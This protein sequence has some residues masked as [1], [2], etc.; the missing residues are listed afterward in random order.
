MYHVIELVFCLEHGKVIFS[1][2]IS[3]YPAAPGQRYDGFLWAFAP[4]SARIQM[5]PV[6]MNVLRTESSGLRSGSCVLWSKLVASFLLKILPPVF[7][8]LTP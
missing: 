1:G 2:P 5:V 4:G 6:R 3:A 7:Y 8:G